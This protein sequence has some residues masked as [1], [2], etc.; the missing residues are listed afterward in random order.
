MNLKNALLAILAVSGGAICAQIPENFEAESLYVLVDSELDKKNYQEVIMNDSEKGED[1]LLIIRKGVENQPTA[2]EISNSLKGYSNQFVTNY[3]GRYVLVSSGDSSTQGYTSYA[4]EKGLVRIL[5]T[6]HGTIVE[7]ELNSKAG[8]IAINH[9]KGIVAVAAGAE[10]NSVSLLIWKG[11]AVANTIEVFLKGLVA[12]DRISNLVWSSTGSYL[13]VTFEQ[14]N[15]V[16]FYR[17]TNDKDGVGLELK[18][19]PV[20]CGVN[21][22][23]GV[24]SLDEQFFY[25][26]DQ[27]KDYKKGAVAGVKLDMVSGQHE[28]LQSVTANIGPEM[29]RMSPDGK[30][31]VTVNRRGAHLSSSDKNKTRMTSISVFKILKNGK[32]KPLGEYPFPSLYP[33]DMRFDK[34]GSMLAVVANKV[35]GEDEQ[36]EVIFWDF[37]PNKKIQLKL[38]SER[39]V[40][41]RGAHSI[42]V[43]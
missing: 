23:V 42:L 38:R 19:K 40:V 33:S 26:A 29:I 14:S 4:S 34:S 39:L 13:A 17:L 8:P 41:P 32:L 28:F 3:D 37:T 16:A 7:E 10:A 24:F 30:F 15:K 25:A 20:D 21:P 12:K 1:Q 27:N 22:G 11:K 5:D 31:V 43:H 6:K 18:G 2:L 9:L 35:S 36:G